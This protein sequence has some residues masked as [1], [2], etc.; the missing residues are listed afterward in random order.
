MMACLLP[1]ALTLSLSKG[2]SESFDNLSQ[3]TEG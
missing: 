3:S 1:D 2:V